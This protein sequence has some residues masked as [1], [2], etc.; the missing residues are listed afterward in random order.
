M[1]PKFPL[2][3][4]CLLI[5]LVLVCPA[6]A[7]AAGTRSIS[8][9]SYDELAQGRLESVALTSD[10]FLEPSY[11]RRVFGNSQAPIVWDA[12]RERSG[13]VLCATGHDG[14][15][16]RVI[17]EKT[18]VTVADLP[19]PEL[20][21]MVPMEDGSTLIAAAPSGRIYRLDADDN[22]TTHTTLEASFVW[23]MVAGSGGEVWAVTGTEGKL[24][25]ITER[26]GEARVEEV[27]DLESANLLD[28]WIDEAGLI[29]PE[30]CS[31]SAARIPGGCIR[32][33]PTVSRSRWHTTPPPRKCARCVRWATASRWR[34]TPNARPRPSR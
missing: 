3:C 6:V 26:R 31:T 16:M 15:L 12:L 13:S 8:D 29:G 10:G 21:A 22:M 5:A 27:C 28:L 25:R 11:E 4:R 23:R 17:D 33:R 20:T 1:N 34:S 24:F 14:K 9:G 32:S 7:G 2:P 18:S 19:E 30:G